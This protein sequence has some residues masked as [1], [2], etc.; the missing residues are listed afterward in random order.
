[1]KITEN[2]QNDNIDSFEG[3]IKFIIAVEELIKVLKMQN[4]LS[5]YNLIDEDYIENNDIQT[6][7]SHIDFI[8]C[9]FEKFF[10]NEKTNV[11][12]KGGSKIKF[13]SKFPVKY[14]QN[15]IDASHN[16]GLHYYHEV[17]EIKDYNE[18]LK[19]IFKYYNDWKNEY[20][21]L[22]EMFSINDYREHDLSGYFD[23]INLMKRLFKSIEGG[24]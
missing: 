1:M 6:L 12:I 7:G 19:S 18:L 9:D 14:T 8:P 20:A 24:L 21:L 5:F 16:G 4:L 10:D 17:Y 11:I 2:G 3:R 15:A 23:L 13:Y 22:L